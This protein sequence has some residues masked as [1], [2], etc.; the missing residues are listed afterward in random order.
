MRQTPIASL[1]KHDRSYQQILP[2]KVLDVLGR[3]IERLKSLV[4][5][6]YSFGDN[7]INK[8]VLSWLKTERNRRLEIISPNIEGVPPVF[9][10][11]ESQVDPQQMTASEFFKN[12]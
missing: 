3:N 5:I 2:Y 10:E 11:V 4:S 7:H 8:I 9:K 1:L 12:C 6:D